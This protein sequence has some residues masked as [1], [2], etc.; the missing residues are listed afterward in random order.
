MSRPVSIKVKHPLQSWISESSGQ[1]PE[2]QILEYFLPEDNREPFVSPSLK[3]LDDPSLM[4]GMDQAVQKLIEV[5]QNNQK[6]VILGDYDVDGMTSSALLLRF[7]RSIAFENLQLFIPN[8]FLHGYGLTRSSAEEILKMKPDL[9]ITV[10]NGITAFEEVEKLKQAGIEVIITDHHTILENLIPDSIVINPKQEDC[11]FPDKNLSGVGVAFFLLI[12]LRRKL[13]EINYWQDKGLEPNLTEEL[14]LVALGTLA[15]QVPLTGLNRILTKIGLKVI[16]SAIHL[17]NGLTKYTYLHTFSKKT[18]IRDIDSETVA[19]QLAPLLNAAGRMQDAALGV[20]FLLAN[21]THHAQQVFSLLNKL[22]LQRK[23]KGNEMFSL[24]KEMFEE[25][26]NPAILINHTDFHEGIIGIV[27]SRMAETY[28]LPAFI[29]ARGENNQWKGSGRSI[30]GINLLHI[31]DQCTDYLQRYGGHAQ[32]AGC[33]IDDEDLEDFKQSFYQASQAI[34]QEEDG[35]SLIEA[36]LELD[37]RMLSRKLLEPMK[38]L[39]PFGQSN[40]RPVFFL[41]GL[42]LGYPRVLGE[43]HFKW[44]WNAEVE[45]VYWNAPEELYTDKALDIAFELSDNF[46][47]GKRKLQLNI[48]AAALSD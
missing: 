46:F 16:N 32:A 17:H 1:S 24:S 35:H 40:P 25:D 44:E 22:N 34:S 45:F 20:E 6:I 27:A 39:E 4:K 3:S 7:F 21:E 47:R 12:A 2:S 36:D 30:E 9:V 23:E 5:L 41:K 29:F 18:G 13:R 26:Q 11:S 28:Q 42:E 19:F 31:L 14:D 38:V 37:I 48:K 10:D 43:K 15:D 8:R 33:T